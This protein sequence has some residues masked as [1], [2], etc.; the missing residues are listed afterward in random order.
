MDGR[1]HWQRTRFDMDNT[2]YCLF[3]LPDLVLYRRR[4]HVDLS[5]GDRFE[6]E[7]RY[8]QQTM[9]TE[10]EK[11]KEFYLANDVVKLSPYALFRP[12]WQ[13]FVFQRSYH[14]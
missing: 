9:A 5:Y 6:S 2:C 11:E 13:L 10:T 12:Y 7:L 3:I 1:K 4:Y 14:R 8:L